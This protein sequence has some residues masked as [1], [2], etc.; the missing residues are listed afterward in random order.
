MGRLRRGS[1]GGLQRLGPWLATVTAL[2]VLGLGSHAALDWHR[3]GTP[4]AGFFHLH[5]HFGEHDHGHDHHH[6]T[7]QHRGDRPSPEPDGPAEHRHAGV[8]TLSFGVAA[9][10]AAVAVAVP[11]LRHDRNVAG[12]SPRLIDARLVDRPVPRAPPV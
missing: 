2:A 4:G 6:D 1:G 12:R 10:P 8:L 11:N 3:H 9:A 5:V 7:G